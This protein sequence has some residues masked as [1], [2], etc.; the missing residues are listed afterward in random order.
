MKIKRDLINLVT[1]MM[2]ALYGAT[3]NVHFAYYIGP[4][5]EAITTSGQTSIQW[6]AI[7]VNDYLNR[8]LKT[9]KVDYINYA[10][11][12][13]I[14]INMGPLVEK[15]FGTISPDREAAENFLDKVFK[16]KIEPELNRACEE[17]A[18]HLGAYKNYM[19]MKREK[20]TDVFLQTGKKRYIASI[21]NSEGVH[22]PE[23]K[24]DVTG[25]ESV[26]SSTPQVVRDKMEEM[27]KIIMTKDERKTQEAIAAFYDEFTQL[28]P[29][30][31]A[32]NSGLDDLSKYTDPDRIYTSGCPIHVRGALLY[33]H[34]IDKLGL[35]KKYTKIQS[36]DKIKFVYLKLPNPIHENVIGFPDYIPKEFG[37]DDYVDYKTQFEKVFLK[38]MINLFEP[39]GWSTEQRSTLEDFFG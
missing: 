11:T 15:I 24:I 28:K 8:I 27:F 34:T 21:L 22:Y 4:M 30:D 1:K 32:R 33:N 20:I 6:V 12:D 14:M 19:H 17:L 3:A 16:E 36:G 9:E 13:S 23:P 29:V 26:R 35:S 39:I 5:A 2:N 37:L 10:D 31:V 18:E 25:I 38:P 7:A